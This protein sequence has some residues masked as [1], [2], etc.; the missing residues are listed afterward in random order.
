MK[1]GNIELKNNLILA[2]MAG[3]TD[4]VFRVI[5][6]E[7]GAGL[8]IS[9]MVSSK[10][11]YYGDRKTAILADVEPKE[12]PIAVQIFG[13]D[14]NIMREVVEKHI[15]MREDIDILDINMGCP[16][17]K[18]VKNGDGA[19]LLK[20]PLLVRE[21]L[22]EVV[23]VSNK[24]VTLKIRMGWDKDNING[25]EIGKIAEEEGISAIIIH[26][27]TRDMFYS[28]DADW[29][30]I[31]R[32]KESLS[33]PV[34]GN[35]DIFE[36]EDAIN[37][38]KY[39]GCDGVAVG[40]GALGNPWIFKRINLLLEGKEDNKPSYEDIIHMAIKHL[41]VICNM[42]GEGIGVR[43]MRKHIAWYLKGLKNSNRVK[44]E[45][46]AITDK[47]KLEETLLNY[48]WELDGIANN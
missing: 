22:R 1:I 2:P 20:N 32:M 3:V 26:A 31:K 27:R 46:N 13:S 25:I 21:I 48:L 9:E 23:K 15:N 29:S 5:C 7:M 39:T 4:K 40:R 38:M 30:F 18:T 33:I 12:R 42:K 35:G 8:V 11:L 45:I 44:N 28:G 36:P 41:T 19:R 43:E 37:M 16:A 34:I 17:P 14:P 6:K 24:P 10:G 47:E